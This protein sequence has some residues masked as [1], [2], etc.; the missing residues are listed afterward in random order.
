MTDRPGSAQTSGVPSAA[1]GQASFES[2]FREELGYVMNTLRRLGVPDRDVEDVAHD[3]FV[4]AY[5]KHEEFDPQRPRRPWLFGIALRVA[6]D[7]RRLFRNR[8]ERPVFDPT[9]EVAAATEHGAEDLER[10]R[11]VQRGLDALDL[12]KRAVLVLHDVEG[13]AMPEVAS[14]LGIPLNTAYSR[15]R[16]ARERFRAAITGEGAST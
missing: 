7:H 10:R 15:L 4:V 6:A 14:A 1:V 8:F 3:V 11:I 5:R 2:M 13:H 12:D 9:A 16:A